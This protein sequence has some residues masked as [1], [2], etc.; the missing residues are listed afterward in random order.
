MKS[1]PTSIKIM[2]NEYMFCTCLGAGGGLVL[3]EPTCVFR[4]Q[5]RCVQLTMDAVVKCI[6]MGH[7]HWKMF[8][9]LTS[10]YW[11]IWDI[12]EKHIEFI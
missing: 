12:K 9:V 8:P 3:A 7:F 11:S 2:Q 10:I 6:Y 4:D 1:D 5:P